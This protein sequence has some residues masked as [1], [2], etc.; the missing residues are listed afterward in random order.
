MNQNFC[1]N[2]KHDYFSFAKAWQSDSAS[3]KKMEEFGMGTMHNEYRWALISKFQVRKLEI[4]HRA[5]DRWKVNETEKD[6]SGQEGKG[7]GNRNLGTQVVG[8]H[9][10]A[11]IYHHGVQIANA[12]K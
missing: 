3:W 11:C 7:G 8:T 10:P 4:E 6:R 1:W 12:S 9:M 5:R 2:W